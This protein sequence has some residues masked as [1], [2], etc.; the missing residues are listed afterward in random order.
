MIYNYISCSF[1]H[2][3]LLSLRS[4]ARGFPTSC[5]LSIP[6]PLYP[7]SSPLRSCARGF[8]A[9]RSPLPFPLPMVMCSQLPCELLFIH[10]APLYPCSSPFGL[11]LAASPRVVLHFLSPYLWLCARGFPASC[12]LSIPLHYIL[13]DLPCGLVLA[14]SPRV[15]LHF[16][17][18]TYGY[19]L[20]ATLRVALFF[21]H[22]PIRIQCISF[23][24]RTFAQN[25]EYF[26]KNILK[27]RFF[28]VPLQP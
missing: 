4:C 28:Y 27:I 3:F 26:I 11:V 2:K 19:V 5:Y 16:L 7:C 20:A 25:Y 15:V 6:S 24:F 8:P 17:S 13:V 22:N 10:P 23:L 9:S 18:P 1:S 14:A 21:S 12:Y